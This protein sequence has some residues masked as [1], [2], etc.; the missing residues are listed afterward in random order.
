V[1]RRVNS[2]HSSPHKRSDIPTYEWLHSPHLPPDRSRPLPFVAALRRHHAAI[3]TSRFMGANYNI[4][5]P[6]CD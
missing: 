3:T 6:I 5:F 1:A 4:T 2:P